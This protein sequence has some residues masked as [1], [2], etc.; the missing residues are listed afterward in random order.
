MKVLK[1]LVKLALGILFIVYIPWFT[2]DIIL[3]FNEDLVFQTTMD[4][5]INGFIASFAIT[6]IIFFI[7]G[8]YN[9]ID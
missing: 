2:G 4:V 8:I 9:W 6:L 3:F 5:W 1:K 7:M